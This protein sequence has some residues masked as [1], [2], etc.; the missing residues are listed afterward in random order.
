MPVKW[1]Y[2]RMKGLLVFFITN[3]LL[4]GTH[5]FAGQGDDQRNQGATSYAGL[6]VN[7]Y[8][9]RPHMVYQQ[10]AE[11]GDSEAQYRLG[12]MHYRGNSIPQDYIRAY[13]WWNIAASKGNENAVTNLVKVE[14]KMTPEQLEKAQELARLCVVKN[15]KGC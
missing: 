9:I 5:A 1:H 7:Q 4:F 13:M 2:G 12:F 6:S 11:Q 15:Y 14:K 10:A 3:I 8:Y